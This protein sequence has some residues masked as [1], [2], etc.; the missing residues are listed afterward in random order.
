TDESVREA[1]SR[2]RRRPDVLVDAAGKRG[3]Q[4][5]RAAN[6][7]AEVQVVW[8]RPVGVAARPDSGVV[9]RRAR[10]AVDFD[11]KS[12][13]AGLPAEPPEIPAGTVEVDRLLGPVARNAIAGD[14]AVG[15]CARCAV[16]SSAQLRRETVVVVS[17]VRLVWSFLHREHLALVPLGALVGTLDH[18][19]ELACLQVDRE[20]V[21][22]EA[23][24]VEELRSLAADELH[25]TIDFTSS[26]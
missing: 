12:G 13:A 8:V 3:V 18:H 21:T 10:W 26:L 1:R 22:N 17:D 4:C 9:N 15:H 23:V 11:F 2:P 5:A 20:A 7:R 16:V 24:V 19:R 6:W 25:R 14:D